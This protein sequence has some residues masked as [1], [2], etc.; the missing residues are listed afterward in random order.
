MKFLC[1]MAVTVA[2]INVG[3]QVSKKG[4]KEASGGWELTG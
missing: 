1:M 3:T 4:N 2:A